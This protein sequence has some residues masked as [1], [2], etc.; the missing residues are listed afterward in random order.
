MSF[1][2]VITRGEKLSLSATR[3]RKTALVCAGGGLTGAMYEIGVLRALSACLPQRSVNGFDIYV[4][5]SAGAFVAALLANDVPSEELFRSIA[6][7]AK[8]VDNIKRGDIFKLN[9]GEFLVRGAILPV[10]AARAALTYARTGE[11]MSFTDA[12]L[13]LGEAIPTSLLTNEKVEAYL[14][15]NLRR[16]GRTDDFRELRHEL[17]VPAVNLDSG[18]RVVFGESPRRHV[19]ISRAVRASSSLPIA[20]RPT[21]VEGADY[22]DGAT[23]KNFHLD[24]AI[25]HGAELIVCINPL[26]PLMHDPAQ[27][28]APLFSSGRYLAHRGLPTLIN[29][30]FRLIL[31]SRMK[32]GFERAVESAPHVD[33]IMFEPHPQDYK[34]FFYNILRYSVRIIIAKHGF[35][36]ARELIERHFSELEEIFAEYELPLSRDLLDDAYGELQAG[37]GSLIAAVQALSGRIRGRI[38]KRESGRVSVA[39]VA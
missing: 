3:R 14:R 4:G 34:M 7:C 29:Q 30:A 8:D 27:V 28:A 37:G 13:M 39:E 15:R 23:E 6:G 5:V 1:L 11:D 22:I 9:W 12:V 18:A 10:I 33:I 25:N 31:H 32:V 20:F 36:A 16:R 35:V 19:P 24:V 21:R 26:V 2:P 38:R 17:Y